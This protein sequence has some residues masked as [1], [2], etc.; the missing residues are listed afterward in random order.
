MTTRLATIKVPHQLI[1]SDDEYLNSREAAAL[2]K[3]S[4]STL[5]KKVRNIPHSKLG[6][7]LLFKRSV[8]LQLIEEARV[9]T[10]DELLK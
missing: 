10:D 1:Y 3:I 2:L 9:P 5:Y 8:L 4:R 7:G 6:K